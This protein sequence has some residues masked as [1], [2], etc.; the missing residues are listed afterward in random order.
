MAL[1][2]MN[3]SQV[4]RPFQFRLVTVMIAVTLLGIL[5][6]AIRWLFILAGAEVAIYVLVTMSLVVAF[7]RSCSAGWWLWQIWERR[8]AR[9]EHKRENEA[10]RLLLESSEVKEA[11]RAA[12]ADRLPSPNGSS[13]KPS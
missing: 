9:R 3:K 11:I 12:Q 5:C 4:L 8:Q 13:V 1:S 6:G 7:V 10:M 2:S